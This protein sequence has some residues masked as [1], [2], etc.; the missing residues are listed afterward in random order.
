MPSLAGQLAFD[1]LTRCK[2]TSFT[3]AHNAALAV[4]AF[5]TAAEAQ[6]SVEFNA[7]AAP[8]QHASN[9]WP[10]TTGVKL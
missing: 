8:Y 10:K 9:E 7:E 5:D 4:G 6:S 2:Y 3:D 1:P